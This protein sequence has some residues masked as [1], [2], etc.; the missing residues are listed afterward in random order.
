MVTERYRSGATIPFTSEEQIDLAGVA[1][2]ALG[3]VLVRI[4]RFSDGQFY[5][6]DDDTFKA[7]AH[8]DI[9]LTL[10]AIATMPGF[11]EGE[12]DTSLITNE[13]ADDQYLIEINSVT[14][15]TRRAIGMAYLGDFVAPV[16]QLK[17]GVIDDD[18]AGTPTDRYT[19]AFHEDSERFASG[20]SAVSIEIRDS[21]DDSVLVASVAMVQIAATGIFRHE[22][23]ANRMVDGAHYYALVTFTIAGVV[24]TWPQWIGRDSEAP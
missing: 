15:A 10:V 24:K 21:T 23:T 2:S 4:R 20:V 9:D 19:V 5:D 12:W 7:A 8:V 11:Y 18:A 14:S 16:Y 13:V 6:F 22:E 3:D 17:V 1:L